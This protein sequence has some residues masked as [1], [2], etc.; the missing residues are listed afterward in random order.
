M[1]WPIIGGTFASIILTGDISSARWGTDHLLPDQDTTGAGGLSVL[2]IQKASQRVK[3]T[4]KEYFQGSGVQVG[5]SQII[6]G[7]TWD[8]TVR[9]RSDVSNW[10]QVGSTIPVVD[11]ANH[12]GFGVGQVVTAYVMDNNYEAT[13]G[14]PGEKTLVLEKITLIEPNP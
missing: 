5:R 9:D 11:M 3:K 2:A 7:G 6:H 14:E 10:P 1:S 8:I 12:F 4:D 13:S